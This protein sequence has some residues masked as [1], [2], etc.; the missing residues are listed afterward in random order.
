[1]L[2]ITEFFR[3]MVYEGWIPLAATD[4]HYKMYAHV[5]IALDALLAL[6]DD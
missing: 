6:A 5:K 1:M 4:K 2:T 3:K